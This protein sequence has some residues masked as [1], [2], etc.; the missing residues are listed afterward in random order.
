MTYSFVKALVRNDVTGNVSGSRFLNMLKLARK[1]M[2][3]QQGLVGTGFSS[4]VLVNMVNM[5]KLA[6]KEMFTQQGL[7]GTGFSS[8]VLVNMVNM[9]KLTRKEMFTQ[10]GLLQTGFPFFW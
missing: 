9:L 10:Q 8:T 7:V 3:T 2:F 1:E 5:L 4:T 6:H